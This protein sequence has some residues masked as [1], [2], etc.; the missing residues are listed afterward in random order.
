MKKIVLIL[1]I[2]LEAFFCN[3]QNWKSGIGISNEFV[4]DIIEYNRDTLLAGVE[5][6]GV[7]I[8][9][10]N[11]NN[12]KQFALKGESVYSLIKIGKSIIAGTNGHDI[13]KANSINL[14]W[15]RVTIN[16]LVVNQL[17][18]NNNI[19]YACTRGTSGP[20]GIYFSEDNA[21]TWKKLNINTSL[22]YLLNI[23]INIDFNVN[24]RIFVATPDGA[25]YCDNQSSWVKTIGTWGTN[26]TVNYIGKD[27]IIYGNE[28]DGIY[29]SKDNGVSAQLLNVLA[30][31]TFFIDDTIYAASIDK[32]I[33]SKSLNANWENMNLNRNVN[34]LT[35][36]QNHLF[37]ATTEGV[38][39]YNGS[40]TKTKSTANN[41][42]T[43]F[44]N[45][46]TDL[47]QVK[48]VGSEKF[49]LEILNS[50]GQQV[51]KSQNLRNDI[52]DFEPGVY[53]T[54][55]AY[56]NTTIIRKIVKR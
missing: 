34:S 14:P 53:I 23:F 25:Y 4:R 20:G 12:W 48:G 7:F 47:F 51:L 1:I 43:I 52:S 8:S 18:S 33:S 22:G 28:I 38:F 37:A 3:A 13:H 29:L 55:I 11:G 16:N 45:P 42:V 35:K 41:T 27:S 36:I 19:V 21:L 17:K 56:Q 26:W 49:S 6:N 31:R 30:R 5:R 50:K 54:K 10:D 2:V 44:P 9:Y 15:E 46:I 40:M 32:L 24:G 39:I